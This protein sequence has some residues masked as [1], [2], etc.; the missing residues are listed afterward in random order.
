MSLWAFDALLVLNLLWLAWRMLAARD[1]FKAVVLFIAFGLL[2]SLAWVRLRAPDV[3]LA[4]AAIG[5]GLTGALFLAAL[6]RMRGDDEEGPAMVRSMRAGRVLLMSLS[7]V[8]LLGLAWAVWTLP[9]Y[10]VGLTR[11]V[12]AA[13]PDSGVENPVTAVL[14]NFRAYDTLLELAV[15]LLAVLGVW[16]LGKAAPRQLAAPPS[17]V[18]RAIARLLLPVMVLVAGYLLWVG[19]HA[20]GGA[21]QGG[22]VLGGAAVLLFLAHVALPRLAGAWVLRLGL[23]LG[24]MVFLAVALG[25]MA[26]GGRLLE[27][28]GSW[29]GLLI[30]GV[31]AAA[32]LSIGLTLAAL[33]AGGRPPATGGRASDRGALR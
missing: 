22:A 8:L 11:H 29:A 5:A 14:L 10:S 24:L 28:P 17:P 3:A 26:L 15:L 21:F 27:Y 25:V 20:P 1:L 4:E 33:F 12:L 32:T 23:A 2:M 7:G 18:L 31:E 9:L 16:S 6:G 13:L 30:L 19:G